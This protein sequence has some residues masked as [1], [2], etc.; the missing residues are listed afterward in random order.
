M[1][2]RDIQRLQAARERL[3]QNPLGSCALAG[4]TLPIDRFICYGEEIKQLEEPLRAA[5]RDVLH[6]D[7]P[8]AALELVKK[9]VRAGETLLL[10]GSNGMRLDIIRKGLE[11]IRG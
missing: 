4:T 8:E 2:K 10:K 6:T 1:F 5:G 3:N 9:T 7:S 11:E